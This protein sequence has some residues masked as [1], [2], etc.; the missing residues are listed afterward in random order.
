M[1]KPPQGLLPLE[2]EPLSI[3]FITPFY[4]VNTG[5][6]EN[7]SEVFLRGGLSLC[8]NLIDGCEGFGMENMHPTRR[9]VHLARNLIPRHEAEIPKFQQHE[10]IRVLYL[11]D[12]RHNL[13]LQIHQMIDVIVDLILQVDNLVDGI[14]QAMD[15]PRAADRLRPIVEVALVARSRKEST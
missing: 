13:T 3:L 15:I 2:V 6:Q 9:V 14:R 8:K 5:T 7:Y 1:K 12:G 11:A 10:G 4:H